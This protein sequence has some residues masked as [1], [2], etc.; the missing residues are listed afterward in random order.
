MEPVSIVA[1]ADVGGGG[2]VTGEGFTGTHTVAYS[3]ERMGMV[4]EWMLL[5]KSVRG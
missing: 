1:P 2:E 5:G 4:R 3:G